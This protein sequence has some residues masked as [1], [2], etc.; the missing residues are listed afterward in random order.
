M[1]EANTC[2]VSR[3]PSGKSH[4]Q[5]NLWVSPIVHRVSHFQFGSSDR[6]GWKT[7]PLGRE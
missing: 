4:L 7:L 6:R 5:R 1:V 3:M 2:D